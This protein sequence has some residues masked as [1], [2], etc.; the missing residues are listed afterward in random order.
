M[1]LP[2]V[3]GVTV[4]SREFLVE[5]PRVLLLEVPLLVQTGRVSEATQ[6]GPGLSMVVL[7]KAN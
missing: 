5:L 7:Q 6:Q 1:L 4:S 3:A 2:Q